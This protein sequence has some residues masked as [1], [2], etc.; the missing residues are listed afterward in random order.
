MRRVSGIRNRTLN[1]GTQALTVYLPYRTS[2]CKIVLVMFVEWPYLRLLSVPFYLIGQD[3]QDY[4]KRI[5]N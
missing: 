1:V 3:F 4:F 5:S 2:L